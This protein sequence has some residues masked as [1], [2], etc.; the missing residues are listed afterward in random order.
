VSTT[1]HGYSSYEEA[2]AEH[3]WNVPEHFNIAADVCDKHPRGKAAM[4]HERFDGTVREVK[5][6]ELQDMANRFANVL[7]AHGVQKGDRV[8][9]L[10]PPE[11][12]TA[13]AFFG[14]WKVGAILL[15]M[16][17]L[18]GDEGIRHRVVDSQAKVLVTNQAN[19]DRIEPSLVEQILILDD[20]LL[21]QGSTEFQ[22]AD[23][24]AEDPAQL[25]YTSG[26]TG[27]AKGILHAHRYILGHEEFVYCHDVRDGERFHGMGEWA[28][29][30][31]ICP[32]IG[33]WRYG[34]VQVVYQREGGFDP[35]RQLDFLSRH[36]VANV[37]GT[38]RRWS[39]PGSGPPAPG[40]STSA[41]PAPPSCRGCRWPRRR[42]S[43][44]GPSACCWSA[45]TSSPGSP[46]TTTSAPRRCS[47]TPPGR[48]CSRRPSPETASSGRSC[49]APTAPT[50]RRSS[51]PTSSA[52]CRWT[53]PRCTATR[54]PG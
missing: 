13:A 11:A 29:A 40:R 46:T 16:S 54:W 25:Y 27:L 15:S 36:Q 31:G 9:M 8:A 38:P 24:L 45:P 6:G 33:P 37:F 22:T 4:I 1:A 44:A 19:A 10:L 48:S 14:T 34:A 50:A 23:T 20:A 39:P 7:V 52:R 53:V 5:W 41:P 28:W 21:A 35:H 3:S 17:V 18:Y 32:L 12:E 42:S 30:A 26:T 51:P 49:S 2:C 47:P 43:A